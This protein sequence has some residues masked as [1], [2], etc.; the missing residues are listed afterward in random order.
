[1]QKTYILDMSNYSE[2]DVLDSALYRGYEPT[3]I[4]GE[5]SITNPQT[6]LDY[7]EK[8]FKTMADEWFAEP[9]IRKAVSQIDAQRGIVIDSVR[10][11]VSSS[12]LI[13]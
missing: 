4:I 8:E 9:L 13:Q 12:T 1:M 10:Q 3:L 2:Q 11:L 7:L 6:P 5:E